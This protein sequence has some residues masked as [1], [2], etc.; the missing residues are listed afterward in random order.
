MKMKG[1]RE[2]E[3]LLEGEKFSHPGAEWKK[4]GR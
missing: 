4:L 1:R 3:S 2:R